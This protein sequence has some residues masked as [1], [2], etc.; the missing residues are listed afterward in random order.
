MTATFITVTVIVLL[1]IFIVAKGLIIV[2][3]SETMVIERLG[4]YEKTLSSGVNIIFP[5]IDKPRSMMWRY[6]TR[7]IKGD[8]LVRVVPVTRIDLRETVYDFDRQSVIT[9]DNVVTEIN[10][11]LYFQI[12]DP[13]RA[14]YEISNLP[15]AIEMLTQ[16]S[17]RNVIGEM[18]LDETLTSRDTIN[19]KLRDILDEAT[20]KWGVKVNRI[21]L[22]DINPPRDIRDAME[23]QMRAERDKRAQ[24]LTAEGQKEAAIR[25][26][27]GKMQSSINHAEGLKQAEILAAEAERQS[28]ILRAEGE[29]SAINR[30]T[31]ALSAS[32]ADPTQYLIAIRY[33]ETLS[34]LSEGN[35]SKLVYLPYEATGILSALGGIKEIS[36]GSIIP[37]VPAEKN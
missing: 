32:G 18:D 4:R 10:A 21:E 17:L 30:I 15:I 1:V 34:S 3:Q 7:N 35:K 37:S 19:N 22:Q 11:V 26:S 29:A 23:K 28:K 31:E 9:R 8:L 24:I 5:F 2:Q 20:N 14:M 6:T 16:T 27:E 36:K 33:L 25:E 13:T 12:V